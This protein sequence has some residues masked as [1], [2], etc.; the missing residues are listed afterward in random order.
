MTETFLLRGRQKKP[1]LPS[2]L[3]VRQR[4]I[5]ELDH[6]FDH[7]FSLIC[8]PAGYGKSTL[9][10]N[11]LETISIPFAW[12][13]LNE[14]IDDLDIFL[15]YLADALGDC[16]PGE[17]QH[18]VKLL[19]TPQNPP[20]NLLLAVFCDDLY[21]IDQE[22]IFILDDYHLINDPRINRFVAGM[23]ENA[24]RQFHL[25][26]A[27]RWNPVFPVMKWRVE[28]KMIE[29]RGEQLLF[30]PAEIRSFLNTS[31]GCALS[32]DAMNMIS[33]R[34]EGWIACLRLI[35]LSM[36]SVADPETFAQSIQNGVAKIITEY[37][38][39]QVYA[40][41]P[42]ET[43]GFLLKTSIL[44]KMNADLCDS[45]EISTG[46][47]SQEVLDSLLT[48]NFF[49]IPLD[50]DGEWYRYHHLIKDDLQMRLKKETSSLEI[51][52]LHLR[53]ARWLADTGY[54]EEAIHHFISGGDVTGAAVIIENKLLE[55]METEDRRRLERW[56][57]DI[58]EDVIDQ[59][60]LLL[61]AK[62]LVLTFH[63]RIGVIQ[64]ILER[65]EDLLAN[66]NNDNKSMQHKLI[67]GL[68]QMFW[69]QSTFWSGDWQA[70]IAY[71]R[72]G[73]E[74]LPKEY[75]F[76]QGFCILYQSLGMKM[77]GQEDEAIALLE[78][79]VWGSGEPF[80]TRTVRAAMALC[81]IYTDL[82]YLSQALQVS[83]FLLLNS[84]RIDLPLGASWGHYFAGRVHLVQGDFDQALIHFKSVSEVS[85]RAH[86]GAAHECFLGLALV[87]QAQGAP[88]LADSVLDSAEALAMETENRRHLVEINSF[89]ARI[90]LQCGEIETAL[91]LLQ[92]MF[93]IPLPTSPIIFLE[94]PHLTLARVWISSGQSEY[95]EKALAL[96]EQM[97]ET[98]TTTHNVW[99]KT[100]FLL[101]RSLAYFEQG[102]A[103]I[104][105]CDLQQALMYVKN[106]QIIQMLLEL[107]PSI[108]S[109]VAQ[110]NPK[111]MVDTVLGKF[112]ADDPISKGQ[113]LIRP[114]LSLRDLTEREIEVLEL[115]GRRLSYDEVAQRLVISPLTVKTHARNIY[116]KLGVNG[117]REAVLLARQIGLLA[118]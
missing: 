25:V 91:R 98:V 116:K 26:M 71:G 48:V 12:L 42:Q 19:N 36:Q 38:F 30:Q 90:A 52:D 86:I 21:E 93:E 56:L 28:E 4:L 47:Y 6:A 84:D 78:K 67:D 39:E 15:S 106:Y 5:D 79:E 17:F 57:K 109:M 60:P 37:L 117:R 112:Y 80:N 105:L 7:P 16:Y 45:L 97:L 101:V 24:P 31:L 55:I 13:T 64:V 115:F 83:N 85:Y 44:S 72:S 89:R 99:R 65:V 14:G 20:D 32:E 63:F 22:L 75:H 8:A 46:F 102:R 35:V 111:L 61:L 29:I 94:L 1:H 82:G 114:G 2:D 33:N 95:I 41:L 92:A 100:E 76:G 49:L 18:F 110:L 118:S 77:L 34:T 59:R 88:K 40:A 58:P 3:Y 62:A 107:K 68:L 27:T 51:A 53:A 23:I 103:D 50:D 54:I 108:Q 87:Y 74:N 66:G 10:S 81:Q 11:W 70:A 104:A 113:T 96:L 73:R 43:R 69:S 9:L